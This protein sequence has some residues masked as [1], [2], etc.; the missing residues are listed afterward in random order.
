MICGEWIDIDSPRKMAIIGVDGKFGNLGRL[1][2]GFGSQL[3]DSKGRSPLTTTF[4][5]AVLSGNHCDPQ[6]ANRASSVK[7]IHG[8]LGTSRQFRRQARV[9][10]ATRLSNGSPAVTSLTIG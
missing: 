7:R 2:T 8:G 6:H 3:F 4:P 5:P 10:L 1:K 9:R